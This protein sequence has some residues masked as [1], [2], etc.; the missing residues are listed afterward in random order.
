MRECA[1]Y[2][3]S[4][5]VAFSHCYYTCSDIQIMLTVYLMVGVGEKLGREGEREVREGR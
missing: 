5:Y 1:A 2:Y 3:A 4:I